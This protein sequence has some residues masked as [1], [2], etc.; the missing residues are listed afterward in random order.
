MLC[1]ASGF[2]SLGTWRRG[3]HVDV[4]ELDRILLAGA[5]VLLVAIVAIRLTG[6]LGLPSLLIYLLMGLLLGESGRAGSS[7]RMPSSRMPSGS[8]PWW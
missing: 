3:P 4:A 5:A 1:D 2:S 8:R 6:R 7:S